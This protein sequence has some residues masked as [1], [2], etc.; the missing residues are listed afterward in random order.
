[1]GR[2]R[3]RWVVYKAG[4]SNLALFFLGAAVISWLVFL[5]AT[6]FPLYAWVY[7]R[8]KPDTS[9]KM[10][11]ILAG[12]FLQANK[13]QETQARVKLPPYDVSLPDGHWLT[14]PKIGVDTAI[15]EASYEEH[16][17]A[18]RKGVWR[19]PNFGTPINGKRPIILAAHRFGY[20]EWSNKY[21]RQ[22]SFFNLPKLKEGDRVEIV[23]D[24]RKFEYR[25]V[26]I[27]EAEKITDYDVDLILYTCKFLV[28]P[29]K[30]FVYLE[31]E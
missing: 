4:P 6:G 22:N 1:M 12:D 18:L 13:N 14:I 23:W 20:L 3:K 27:E 24:K 10:G 17:K 2:R 29:V 30:Y 21:R 19:V 5:V 15:W 8:V 26:K 25:V 7:Y 9:V 28:S 16:E 31:R 11:E